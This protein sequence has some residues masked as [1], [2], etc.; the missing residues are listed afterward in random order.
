[1]TTLEELHDQGITSFPILESREYG[2]AVS[3]GTMFE[4]DASFNSDLAMS[5]DGENSPNLASER[6]EREFGDELLQ[7]YQGSYTARNSHSRRPSASRSEEHTVIPQ[8]GLG[9]L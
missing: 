8:R 4:G 6:D 3:P 1:M 5:M 2:E 9:T 7:P